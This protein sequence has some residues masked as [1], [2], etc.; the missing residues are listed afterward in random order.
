MSGALGTTKFAFGIW[1]DTVNVAS[2]MESA[3]KR[4]RV[5]IS[6]RTYAL[7]RDR[8]DCEYR[9]KAVAKGKGE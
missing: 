7:I 8:L 4:G 3:G 5:N 2:R 6:A 9:G 1:G